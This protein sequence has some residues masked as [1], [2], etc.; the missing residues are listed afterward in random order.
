MKCLM[1]GHGA[2]GM[3]QLYESWMYL[4]G[5]RIAVLDCKKFAQ[6]WEWREG[7]VKSQK[8]AWLFLPLLS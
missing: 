6:K 7:A 3:G 2:S 8:L 1:F 4:I 5:T